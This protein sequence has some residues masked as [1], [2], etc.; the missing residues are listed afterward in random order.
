M[1]GSAK[2]VEPYLLARFF[3]LHTEAIAISTVPMIVSIRIHLQSYTMLWR[4]VSGPLS[5]GGDFMSRMHQTE[6][7]I[8]IIAKDDISS[9]LDSVHGSCTVTS[10]IV[11]SPRLSAICK[12]FPGHQVSCV[13]KDP[14]FYE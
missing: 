11:P 14:L 4:H 2:A 6:N 1:Y 7:S 9:A 10:A 3:F 12:Q 8:T 13:P 5:V